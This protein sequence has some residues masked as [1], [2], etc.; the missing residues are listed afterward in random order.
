MTIKERQMT[1]A[2]CMAQEVEY[3]I[4]RVADFAWEHLSPDSKTACVDAL[5]EFRKVTHEMAK[6]MHD[7]TDFEEKGESK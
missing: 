7:H 2:Y 6:F 3:G 1:F 5:E 4:E